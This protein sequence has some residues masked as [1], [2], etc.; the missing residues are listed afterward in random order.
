MKRLSGHSSL[1]GVI[2]HTEPMICRFK[3]PEASFMSIE[4]YLIVIIRC[5]LCSLCM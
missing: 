3:I 4:E 2:I 1:G 5:T